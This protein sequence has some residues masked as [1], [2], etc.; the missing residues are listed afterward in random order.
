M[1]PER[2]RAVRIR[3]PILLGLA[4]SLA[5]CGDGNP[6]DTA[7]DPGTTPPDPDSTAPA[8]VRG[9]VDSV[10][11]NPTA[12]TLIVSG[13][14]LDNTDY[15]ATYTRNPAYDVTNA[16]GVFYQAYT[17]QRD[18]LDR[19]AIAFA[20][21]TAGG[22]RGVVA[23]TGG[24]FNR[25]FGGTS[26]SRTGAFDPPPVNDQNQGLVSYAGQYVG[27]TNIQTNDP[28][29]PP[30][31]GTDPAVIPGAPV[32]VDGE[33][34]L[35]VD[36]A[37]NQVNGAVYNR[38]FRGNPGVFALPDVVLIATDIDSTGQFA[39]ERVEYDGITTL[40]IG[41]YAGIFGGTD[42]AGV[43]GGVRLT[44]FD[45]Q[46]DPN[47]FTSEEEYGIFVLDKCGTP[48]ANAP[49]CAQVRP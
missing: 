23:V 43:A 14:G 9:D 44:Q 48:A 3:F 41:D 42:A 32:I 6:F 35:N 40:D 28:L 45:G 49:V 27:L 37:D 24:Q 47:G 16:A 33:I 7:T 34:F 26:F 29:L 2:G 18:P 10:T 13:V 38:D 19:P 17:T 4:L 5:A 46:G 21:Q 8:A 25:Y 1:K 39:G 11:F 22:A 15:S 12:Q 31:P 30:D 20:R 36:F